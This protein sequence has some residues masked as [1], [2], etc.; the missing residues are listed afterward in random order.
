MNRKHIMLLVFGLAVA[1][2]ASVTYLV[3]IHQAGSSELEIIQWLVEASINKQEVIDKNKLKQTMARG[4]ARRICAQAVEL[5]AAYAHR[6]S[7]ED[8]A[9]KERLRAAV[10]EV[11]NKTLGCP[12]I[13]K[14]GTGEVIDRCFAF[15]MA[16]SCDVLSYELQELQ[17]SSNSAAAGGASKPQ[18]HLVCLG[19]F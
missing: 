9:G 19:V 17:L 11:A 14:V 3:A 8:A 13:W 15:L 18:P 4:R 12:G 5:W 6:C 10:R 7:R 1:V 2:A 16:G